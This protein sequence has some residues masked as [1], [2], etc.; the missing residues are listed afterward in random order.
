MAHA[1]RAPGL[2]LHRDGPVLR[3]SG[4]LGRE[5]ATS[6]W[7]SLLP[8]LD[9]ARTLDLAGVSL[10]DSA[11]VALLA[12]AAAR[13]AA[14]GAPPRLSGA[15]AGLADLCAA[16]RLDATLDYADPAP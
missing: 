9:G 15:P 1:E 14:Q 11:G 3:V 7:P 4:A 2:S 8:L 16:Y 5:T 12:E 13:I 6:A 10:Q